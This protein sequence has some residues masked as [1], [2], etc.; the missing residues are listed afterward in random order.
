VPRQRD[1]RRDEAYEIFKKN[2]GEIQNREI[3][4]LLNLPEKTVGGWKSKDKWID[5][6][7]G[8]LQIK[9]RSTPKKR[10]APRGSKNALGNRGGSAPKRNSNAV[11]HGFFR[12]IFPDDEETFQIIDAIEHKS[13]VDIIWEN[14]VIKYTAI[15]RAQKLMYVNDQDDIVKVLKKEKSMSSEKMDI[16][17]KEWEFQFPWDRHAKLLNA[18]SRA[19]AELRSLI[20]DFLQLSGQDDHRRLQLEKMQHDI[21]KTKAEILQIKG[22]GNNEETDDWVKAI[23]DVANKRRQIKE[24]QHE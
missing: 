4:R 7:N 21:E 11:S 22:G 3:A 9:E 23:K 13:P 15:A 8:V 10:G 1:P 17:E 6:L 20:K 18:Q 19:M 16:N 2:N 24:E 12:T 5:R 14:I